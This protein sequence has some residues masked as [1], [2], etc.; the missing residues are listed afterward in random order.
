MFCK[1]STATRLIVAIGAAVITT[2]VVVPTTMRAQ[3]RLP[4]H[5]LGHHDPIPQRL[6]YNW[7]GKTPETR[8]RPA[9]PAERQLVSPLPVSTAF[10]ALPHVPVRST[11]SD[12]RITLLRLDRSPVLFRGP[13]SRS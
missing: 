6:R 4:H 11:V 7:N 12:E 3:Q 1:S 13:P 5:D 8:M 9:P 2:L 10:S